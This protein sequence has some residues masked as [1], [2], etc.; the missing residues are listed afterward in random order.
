MDISM[1]GR[2]PDLKKHIVLVTDFIMILIPSKRIKTK[3]NKTNKSRGKSEIQCTYK[4]DI[5]HGVSAC[6]AFKLELIIQ[7][8]CTT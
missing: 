6:M 7:L 2:Q 8:N 5:H 3:G 4:G 1:W